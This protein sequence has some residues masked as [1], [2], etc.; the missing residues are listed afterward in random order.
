MAPPGRPKTTETF[1]CLKASNKH[2]APDITAKNNTSMIGA[3]HANSSL[4][5]A[6]LLNKNNNEERK[7]Y[8]NAYRQAAKRNL[9]SKCQRSFRAPKLSPYNVGIC[10]I[11]VSRSRRPQAL[12]FQEKPSVEVREAPYPLSAVAT[13][14][15]EGPK[16]CSKGLLSGLK[17]VRAKTLWV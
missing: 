8:G 6:G 14:Q 15:D 11:S 16:K 7:D 3:Q 4:L 2:F 12:A 10:L 9:R 17:R 5:Q 13:V 1:C